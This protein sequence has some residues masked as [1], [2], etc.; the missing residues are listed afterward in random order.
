VSKPHI[1]HHTIQDVCSVLPVITPANT[2]SNSVS[3]N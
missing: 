1:V 3:Q 2:F